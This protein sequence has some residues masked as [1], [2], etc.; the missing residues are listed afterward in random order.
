MPILPVRQKA[1]RIAQPTCVDT[2]KVC[3]GVSGMYTDST[4]RPSASRR[5]YFVVP[6]RDTS[7]RSMRGLEMAKVAARRARRSRARSV[8]ASKSVTPRL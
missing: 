4:N 2:Q 3:F 7:R 8:I 6:S 5:R 1:H